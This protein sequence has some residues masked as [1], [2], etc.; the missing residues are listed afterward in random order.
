[1]ATYANE[2]IAIRSELP[3]SSKKSDHI[4]GKETAA[5]LQVA[6]E[7]FGLS[8]SRFLT[9]FVD[10]SASVGCLF[11]DAQ[12][13]GSNLTHGFTVFEAARI[14]PA[15]MVYSTAAWSTPDDGSVMPSAAQ[16]TPGESLTNTAYNAFFASAYMGKRKAGG[17]LQKW[18]A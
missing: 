17:R 11:S 2:R 15:V 13:P 12:L 7:S 9:E 16:T 8:R 4:A 10:C 6:H 18:L 3:Q 1:M 5:L 14:G